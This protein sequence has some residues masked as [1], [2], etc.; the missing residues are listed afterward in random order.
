M[1]GDARTVLP[2]RPV[3]YHAIAPEPSRLAPIAGA[4]GQ[5]SRRSL[6]IATTDDSPD[7][8]HAADIVVDVSRGVVVKNRHGRQ[9]R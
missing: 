9:F 6:K 5:D 2:G 8:Q 4:R 1:V 3:T 7:V